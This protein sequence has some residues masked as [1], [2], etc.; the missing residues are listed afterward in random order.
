MVFSWTERTVLLVLL[1]TSAALF[2]WRFRTVV[3][4]I[5][6]SRAT[7]DF[8]LQPLV[9]RVRQFLWE[10]MLQGKVIQ[11]RPLPGIAH[12]LVFWGFCAFAIITVNHF[13]SGLGAPF[14][15]REGALGRFYF[16]FVAVWALAVAV[17]IA[18]LF[19]RRFLVRPEWL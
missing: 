1:V 6:R 19:V 12:A 18:G 7:P 15:S 8:S 10:V 14:L 17:A 2:W 3:N 16:A 9:P 13:A 4:V 5:S 11:Q